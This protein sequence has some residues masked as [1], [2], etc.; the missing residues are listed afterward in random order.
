[1]KN[2]LLILQIVPALIAVVKALEE[3]AGQAGIG[4]EKL[5]AVRQILEAAYEGVS[6]IWPYLEKIIAVVVSFFN[7]VGVFKTAAAPPETKAGI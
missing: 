1:M 3:A 5:S 4:K 6:D 2:V 7:A